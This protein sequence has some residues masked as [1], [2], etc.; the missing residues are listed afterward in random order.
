MVP[1]SLLKH[2]VW[3]RNIV[4][5]GVH[6]SILNLVKGNRN[7]PLELNIVECIEIE[8]VNHLLSPSFQLS[9]TDKGSANISSTVDA[10]IQ[11]MLFTSTGVVSAKM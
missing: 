9:N 11:T 2:Q 10:R 8:K 6:G 1:L 3:F 7:F 4:F 5:V